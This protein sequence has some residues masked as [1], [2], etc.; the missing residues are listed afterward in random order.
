MKNLSLNKKL[1]GIALLL[2]F[3][4]IFLGS[5]YKGSFYNIN[6]KE[7]ALITGNAVDHVKVDELADWIIQGK[8]DYR[9]ID[10]RTEKEFAEYHIPGAEN[11]PMQTLDK[12]DLMKNEKI[13]LY[14][15][16]GIHSAQGWMI[17]KAKDFKGVYILF[18]GLEEW[19]EKILFP[20]IP[21]N[22]TPEQ[23]AAFEK[24][25]EVSK[26]FGGT[27]QTGS[28]ADVK[29]K[30]KVQAPKLEA[31]TTTPGTTSEPKKKKEGC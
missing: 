11:I 26:F 18:G 15:E 13:I 20:K 21:E 24:I 3:F 5:P 29:D 30:P 10:L 6:S 7:L 1:A 16:G 23:L 4:A 17:L 31:P 14:S 2:G 9:I 8:S 22:A 25:K 19:N 27:P 12:A 28:T